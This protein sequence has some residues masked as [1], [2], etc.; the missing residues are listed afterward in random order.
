MTP[1]FLRIAHAGTWPERPGG[2]FVVNPSTQNLVIR[3][4][5]MEQI[6]HPLQQRPISPDMVVLS[7]PD[8]YPTELVK[9]LCDFFKTRNEVLSAWLFTANYKAN[10][11]EPHHLVIVNL[12]QGVQQEELFKATI[13]ACHKAMK[14]GEF[15]DLMPSSGKF[16]KE[17]IEDKSR[18][19]AKESR[20]NRRLKCPFCA[21]L[22]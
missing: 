2:G 21:I 18:S 13:D 9:A 20:L 12:T 15:L 10:A 16:G 11:T 7:K 17:A 8:P 6:A 4:N 5:T 22:I 19:I 3:T 14:A 1:R